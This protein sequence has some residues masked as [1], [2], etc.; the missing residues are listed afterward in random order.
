MNDETRR[1][2][3]GARRHAGGNGLRPSRGAIT[4]DAGRFV[5]SELPSGQFTITVSRASFITSVYGAKRGGRP[6]TPINVTEGA[7]IRDLVVKLW[8]GAAVAGILRDDTGAPVAGIEITAIP[9]RSPGSLPTLTNNGTLTNELGE[10]RIFGLEPGAYV[11]AARPAA[12]GSS[13]YSALTDSQ[14]DAALDALRR[15]AEWGVSF[16]SRQSR[17]AARSLDYAP[18]SFRN[19]GDRPGDAPHSRRRAIPNWF[20]LFAATRADRDD[21]RRRHTPRRKSGR[22]RV[23]SAH[24]GCPEWPVPLECAGRVQCDGRP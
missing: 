20:G 7:R 2:Q 14:T 6:G 22:R 1:S 15:R 24:G 23:A 12:G 21:H 16:R 8:R 4:D 10:F 5:F 17:T 18:V 11:V 3:C 13:Q 9:A 19:A